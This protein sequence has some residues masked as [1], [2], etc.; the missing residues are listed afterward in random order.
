MSAAASTFRR[1]VRWA[2]EGGAAHAFVSLAR[3]VPEGAVPLVGAVIGNVFGGLDVR[4]R[5]IARENV[6]GALGHVL[7]DAAQRRIVRRSFAHFGRVGLEVSRFGRMTSDS[8]HHIAHHEG[9]EHLQ[10][11]HARGRGVLIVSAHFGNWELHA[12]LQGWVGYP[13]GLVVRPMDNP[14]IERLISRLRGQSGNTTLSK[15]RSLGT[16]QSALRR[17]EIVG[18]LVDQRPRHGGILVPFF[19]RPAL[20]SSAPALLAL[21][22]GAAMLPAFSV[23][24]A[25]G[26]YRLVYEPEIRVERSGN[27]EADALRLTAA[28]TRSVER[29]VREYPELW[30]WMHNR[31]KSAEPGR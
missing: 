10:A 27:I 22:T 18:V 16:V 14:A 23:P 4:H 28:Y 8:C 30:L 12:L 5:R 7:G 21:R 6:R 3:L 31:W 15:R 9:L 2:I 26:G 17:G 19:G 29:W 20:T 13:L 1:R 24:R 11:A 25:E